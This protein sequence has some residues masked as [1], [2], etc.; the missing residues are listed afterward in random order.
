MRNFL[1]RSMRPCNMP[2]CRR[3]LPRWYISALPT[4]NFPNTVV[5]IA[6]LIQIPGQRRQYIDR[7]VGTV[8]QPIVVVWDLFVQRNLR[9]G[10]R[11]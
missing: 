4:F 2:Q 6:V 5:Q 1:F 9:C 8:L 10:G 3:V 7:I 11:Y